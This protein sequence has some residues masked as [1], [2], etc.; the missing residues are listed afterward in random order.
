MKT[1]S[2][3]LDFAKDNLRLVV[4]PIAI[5]TLLSL[6]YA[7]LK[8][9]VWDAS[10]ALFIRDEGTNAVERGGRFESTDAMQTAQETIYEISRHPEVLRAA[11]EKVG[12]K[13][14]SRRK[15]PTQN[16]IEDFQ[17]NVYVTAPNGAKF[18][19]TEMIYLT[20]RDRDRERAGKLTGAMAT[21]LVERMKKLRV[22]RYESI[23]NETEKGVS[24]A[25]K[26]LLA[27]TQRLEAI[28]RKF[29]KDLGE[30]RVLADRS[31]GAGNVRQSLTQVET[32]L[33]NAKGEYAK[34]RTQQDQLLS[35]VNDPQRLINM[36]NELLERQT[37]LVRLKEGLVDAQLRASRLMGIQSQRHPDVQAALK[38]V[39]G[40]RN[41]LHRELKNAITALNS[42][43]ARAKNRVI[44]LAKQQDEIGNRM[45]GMAGVRTR[46]ANLN[47][48]VSQRAEFLDQ[49]R[50]NLAIARSNRISAAT[51]SLIQAVESPIPGSRPLGP[52]RKSIVLAGMMAGVLTSMGLIFLMLPQD[53]PNTKRN[54]GKRAADHTNSTFGRRSSDAPKSAGGRDRRHGRMSTPEI[55][56]K[57]READYWS[58]KDPLKN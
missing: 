6:V 10:Q 48:E 5:F 18:G 46:Y 28:E 50:R 24:L 12:P 40:I 33:R 55:T 38:A 54:H 30:L 53:D 29:G 43:I 9:N 45:G 2:E 49:A 51:V 42:D 57:R 3:I 26:E 44:S 19:R 11:L 4:L 36:S 7:I 37:T 27:A 16:H 17:K 41:Q 58:V 22:E 31:Q 39:D 13:R 21:S 35:A 25:Q 23:I 47:A 1:P 56:Y 15:F 52:S 34:L 20:V 8:P 32:E 14:K